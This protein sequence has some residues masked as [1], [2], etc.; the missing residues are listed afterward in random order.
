MYA[1]LV[2]QN[3]FMTLSSVLL[4]EQS[5]VVL[6]LERALVSWSSAIDECD[7]YRDLRGSDC[8]RVI[9]YIHGRIELYCS[10]LALPV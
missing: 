5:D 9:P 4:Q 7:E 2:Y 8:R 10:S 1:T 3:S 6:L